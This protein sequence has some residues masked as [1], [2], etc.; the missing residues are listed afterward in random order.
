MHP[1]NQNPYSK[2]ENSY[3][4]KMDCMDALP[5]IPDKYFDLGII[6]NMYGINQGGQ[7][8]HTRINSTTRVKPKN[9]HCFDDSCPPGKRYYENSFRVCKNVI[10][11][12]ANHFIS[13]L[14]YTDTSCWIVWDK[15][16]GASHFADCELAWTSFRTA[17]RKFKYRW[18]GMLQEGMKNKEVRI[19][20]TQKPV[21]LYEWLLNKYA[22]PKDKILDTHVGS[23]SSRIAAYHLGFDYVG[24]E[25]DEYYCHQSTL[26]FHK[27]LKKLRTKS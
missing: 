16:N 5:G 23:G 27:E 14:P 6:D 7:K 22:H 26:W 20:P 13:K 3:L 18:N 11:W 24:F 4:Y 1:I 21:K 19:H 17:V 25:I 2:H 8:N 12:G 15:D 9:Y 10:I